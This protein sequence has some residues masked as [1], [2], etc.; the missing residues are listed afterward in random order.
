MICACEIFSFI[1]YNRI[2]GQLLVCVCTFIISSIHMR[3]DIFIVCMP[4]P[5]WY[6]YH[7]LGNVHI[8]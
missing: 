1:I 4:R 3:S 8:T 2:I 7:L 6:S 5:F